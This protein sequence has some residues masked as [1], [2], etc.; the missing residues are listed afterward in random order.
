MRARTQFVA[1]CL[2]VFVLT[3]SL[4]TAKQPIRK[5]K[6]DT[7]LPAVDL[8]EAID[9]GLVETSVI[10]KSVNEA[11]LFVTNKSDKAVSVKLPQAVV[12]VQVLK[13]FFPPGGNNNVGLNQ[14]GGNRGQG[15]AAQP[16]GGG[17]QGNANNGN[18]GPGQNG[19]GNGFPNQGN[20]FFSVPSQMTVQVPLRTLCLAHG[21]P[22]P[23]P[24]M[25]YRLV[26]LEDYTGDRVL[27]ETLKLF[28]S[29]Q[30]DAQSA[31]AAVWHLTDKMS[32]D[33]LRAKQID[34]LGLDPV[35]YFDAKQVDDA[36]TL[37]DTARAR[38]S[39]VSPTSETR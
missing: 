14:A 1:A 3:T 17:P 36:E 34:R 24:K 25:T 33:D 11:S 27:Q 7:S 16:L 2:S 31:Q 9:N 13:Q 15:G 29:G 37:I 20:N 10:A 8:F 28:A 23:R 5:L 38:T 21:R 19:Q 12:A 4:A 35:L 32:W 26:K 18:N 22:E 6:Y 30:T 39:D